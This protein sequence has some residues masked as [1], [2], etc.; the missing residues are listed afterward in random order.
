MSLKQTLNNKPADQQL[1]IKTAVPK[2]LPELAQVLL[3]CKVRAAYSAL[4]LPAP[5]ICKN[6]LMFCLV[7]E[8]AKDCPS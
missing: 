7:K 4:T 6:Y 5:R 1:N 8:Q 3:Q 2:E